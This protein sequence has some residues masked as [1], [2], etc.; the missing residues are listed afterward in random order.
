MSQE[1]SRNVLKSCLPSGIFRPHINPDLKQ[2][3]SFWDDAGIS[4][5]NCICMA[6]YI[7]CQHPPQLWNYLTL[8]LCQKQMDIAIFF[9]FLRENCYPS[10]ATEGLHVVGQYAITTQQLSNGLFMAISLHEKNSQTYSWKIFQIMN[11][12]VS[13]Q[14]VPYTSEQVTILSML[15]WVEIKQMVMKPS[16]MKPSLWLI[17]SYICENTIWLPCTYNYLI[18]FFLQ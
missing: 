4:F 14:F 18:N 9:I 15:P 2:K 11:Q 6:D 16:Y 17:F 3:Y 1:I 10:T 13:E 5:T 12:P 7:I 8:E